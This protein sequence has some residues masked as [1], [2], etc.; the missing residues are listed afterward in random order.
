MVSGTRCSRVHCGRPMKL[1]AVVVLSACVAH[2]KPVQFGCAYYPEAWPK[3]NWS[4][5]LDD[6]KEA[7]LTA[8]RIG[9]F[10]W[11]NFE[12]E[13]GR[14]E[15]GDYI[16]IL[17]L[18][19]EKGI[20]VMMCTPSASIP[21]WMHRKYPECEKSR[22]D[23]WRPGLGSRQSRC[24]S[25]AK[26]R[27]FSRRIVERMAEAFKGFKCIKWWQIDN[28]L[29]IVAGL[30]LCECPSCEN[31]FRTWLRD[32]YGAIDELNRK[33]NSSFWSSRF[34]GW[35]DVSLPIQ[36]CREPWMTEFVRYQSDVFV[37][38]ARE[39]RDVILRYFPH[40]RVTSNGSEMSGWIRLDTLYADFGYV[41]T[42][43]YV[44]GS[45]RA[46]DRAKWMW[47]LSRGLTGVQRPFMV[48]EMGPFS[49]D[50]DERNADI[51]VEQWVGEAVKHGAECLFFFRWRQSINGEQYHPAILP[52][53]G[54]KGRTFEMV[55]RISQLGHEAKMPVSSVAILH[56]NESDQ[57]TL[58]RGNNIQYGQYEELS[59]L[60]NSTLEKLGILPDYLMSGPNVDF[61]PYRIVLVPMNTIV[62]PE[63][64]A[65]LKNYVRNGG[66]V[67]AI[68]RLNL[69]DPKGGS[70]YAES[71]P[72]GMTDLFG[73]EINEQRARSD[74][75]YAYDCV[76]PKGCE[77]IAVLKEGV[78]SGSPELTR[79]KYG[80]GIAYYYAKLPRT[81]AEM[82]LLLENVMP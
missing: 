21:T 14:F 42:D 53:S 1:A 47:G 61:S 49:W 56:S 27:F 78:F 20:D 30:C 80:K 48:A 54:K 24:P 17:K 58:V 33:W 39:Q 74:W 45:T 6:M 75:K 2:A 57:D 34:G 44:G 76:E 7:G 72:V 28:E 63:V 9:E 15:F 12:P 73:L 79:M 51:R 64:G 4:R 18:C 71:Y 25:S 60:L 40:V 38:F 68:C 32:R 5:D 3:D 55:R 36:N 37:D 31:G 66:T 29:H 69:I 50:A 46:F 10:N 41:A 77:T 35:E 23:G 82:E 22:K 8:I 11:G 13:E 52:W 70:Y 43:T 62:A 65:R 59:I 81:Q 26:F 19:E 67:A 16:E